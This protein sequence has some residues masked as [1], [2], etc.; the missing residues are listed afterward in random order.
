[1]AVEGQRRQIAGFMG[2]SSHAKAAGGEMTLRLFAAH[3]SSEDDVQTAPVRIRRLGQNGDPRL[4]A[5]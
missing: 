2:A 4:S 5:T 1:M 3:L